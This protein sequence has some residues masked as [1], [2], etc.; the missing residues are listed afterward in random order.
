[1]CSSGKKTKK[2]LS[3]AKV[4]LLL[5]VL[6]RRE[7]GYHDILSVIQPITLY[8]ELSIELDDGE[9]IT[10]ET[11]HPLLPTDNRNLA[12][13]AADVFLKKT[14]I[15]A[16]VR[17]GIKKVIPVSAGLG[18]GSSD[19][20]ITLIGLN[21][22]LKAGLSKR[23][24]MNIGLSLGSDVPFFISGRS[25]IVTG[26]GEGVEGIDLPRFWY[27]LINPGLPV[28]SGW[29][30]QNLDLTKRGEDISITLLEDLL[31]N[32]LAVEGLLINDLEEVV[33]RQHPEV[34]EIKTALLEAG[35]EGA[36]MSGSGPTVFGIFFKESRAVEAVRLLKERFKDRGWGFFVAQ[37]VN[38]VMS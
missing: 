5:K 34:N 30:Y 23:E 32:P 18:G 1:M 15:K 22:L 8:D 31:K 21:E 6:R 37:G 12:F 28:S 17:I 10:V 13:R 27:L 29:A 24:L 36:L 33:A 14:G 11:D 25:A 38:T 26:K 16:K 9:G 3:P 4:N 2:L 19:A 7:D 35:A 20:A